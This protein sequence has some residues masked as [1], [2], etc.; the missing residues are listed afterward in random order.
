MNK[1]DLYFNSPDNLMGVNFYVINSQ[2]ES[3]KYWYNNQEK[4]LNEYLKKNQ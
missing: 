3:V 2:K 4:E 1:D